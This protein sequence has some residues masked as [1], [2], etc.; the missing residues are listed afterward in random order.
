LNILD[1][2]ALGIDYPAHRRTAILKAHEKIYQALSTRDPDAAELAMK[3]HIDSYVRFAR[4]RYP[5][6]FDRVIAWDET[7][8]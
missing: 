3:E 1:G 7:L 2:T 6:L 5:E 8:R 4:K